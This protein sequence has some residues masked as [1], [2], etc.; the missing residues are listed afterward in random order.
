MISDNLIILGM[1]QRSDGKEEPK[2]IL[3]RNNLQ[4]KPMSVPCVG[5]CSWWKL[6]LIAVRPPNENEC[7]GEIVGC[8][9]WRWWGFTWILRPVP[10]SVVP[11]NFRALEGDSLLPIYSRSPSTPC[12][13]FALTLIWTVDRV[14]FVSCLGCGGPEMHA[15]LPGTAAWGRDPSPAG[16]APGPTSPYARGSPAGE[17]GG[18]RSSSSSSRSAKHGGG[19]PRA[20]P[21]LDGRARLRVGCRRRRQWGCAEAAG[22]DGRAARPAHSGGGRRRARRRGEPSLAGE[23]SPAAGSAMVSWIISRLVVWVAAGRHLQRVCLH[24][25]ACLCMSVRCP[26]R[27][28]CC[29]SRSPRLWVRGGGDSAKF[30]R[31]LLGMVRSAVW[32]VRAKIGGIFSSV[33]KLPRG[34][35]QNAAVLYSARWQGR[36]RAIGIAWGS[37]MNGLGVRRGGIEHQRV[38]KWTWI[39]AAALC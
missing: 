16:A 28:C 26:R 32:W 5:K 39:W 36:R 6:D 30:S 2:G 12:L 20:L 35:G 11:A 29:L 27:A 24:I 7:G 18:V 31:L 17:A 19:R 25:R 8:H 9:H 22:P 34:R 38:G 13:S 37:A 1:F 10:L 4:V 33:G 3:G 21:N 23:P 14:C 15:C